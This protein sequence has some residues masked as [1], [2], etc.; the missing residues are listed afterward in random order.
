MR[1]KKYLKNFI[2]YLNSGG[3]VNTTV[4][5]CHVDNY[6]AGKVVLVTGGTSGF[7]LA[8]AKKCLEQGASVIVTGRNKQKMEKTISTIGNPKMKGIVWDLSDVSI[9]K[10]KLQEANSIFGPINVYVNNAGVWTPNNW[11]NIEE[12]DW[13]YVVDINLKGLF[14]MCKEEAHNL[15]IMTDT[16][17]AIGK[18]I[19]V[20]SIEGVR[21]GFGPY[22]A[23]KW[24][25]NGLT[26]GLAKDLVKNKIVVNAVAPGMAITDINPNLPKDGN[27]YLECQPTGRFVLVE[28]I[29]DMVAYLAG[30]AANSIVG[31]VIAIDGGWSLN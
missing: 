12:K 6:L 31:Q 9:V 28:E 26:K 17:D 18:I 4:V 8:I 5:S 24:G 15:K 23:S 7:G 10:N 1:L 2:K 29:A 19:N 16:S 22:C 25:A 3:V 30:D 14:F 13:D 21:G 11:T 27:Q 20:T